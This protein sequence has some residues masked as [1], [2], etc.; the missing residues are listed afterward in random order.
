MT[1]PDANAGRRSRVRLPATSCLLAV[2]VALVALRLCLVSAV[3]ET[4]PCRSLDLQ[5]G[6]E[7]TKEPECAHG[8]GGQGSFR[9]E[10]EAVELVSGDRIAVIEL[11]RATRR[12]AFFRPVLE[13]VVEIVFWGDVV[14][15]TWQGNIQHED[16]Q[17]RHVTLGLEDGET[18]P[19]FG[20]LQTRRSVFNSSDVKQ[21]IYGLVCNLNGL[22]FS[23]GEAAEILSR[24]HD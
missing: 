14:D 8:V 24:I 10:W 3:A 12:G 11:Q 9:L 20:L 15:A 4:V 17:A 1:R 22:K 16:F 6:M 23:D 19:C 18:M 13:E 2:A 5:V 7:P 21:A